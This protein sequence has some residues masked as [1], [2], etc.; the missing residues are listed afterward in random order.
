MS[1]KSEFKSITKGLESL[2]SIMV[3]QPNSSGTVKFSVGQAETAAQQSEA[4]FWRQRIRN[5]ENEIK[6]EAAKRIAAENALQRQT[7]K[8]CQ[9]EN[10]ISIIEGE[11]SISRS[12]RLKDEDVKRTAIYRSL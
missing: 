8:L 3:D 4:T 1:K 11:K 7:E 5:L 2:K 10:K 6:A 9:L 12:G